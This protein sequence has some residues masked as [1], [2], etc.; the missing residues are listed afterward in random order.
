MPSH[1]VS[2][3]TATIGCQDSRRRFPFVAG[4]ADSC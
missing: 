2:N 1:R 3:Q 4:R